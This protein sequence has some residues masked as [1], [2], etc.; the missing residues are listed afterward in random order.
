MFTPAGIDTHL[1]VPFVPT[2]GLRVVAIAP[3]PRFST[4]AV[5]LANHEE[6]LPQADSQCNESERSSDIEPTVTRLVGPL[7]FS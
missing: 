6:L 7:I 5:I 2:D 4:I 3:W 1:I